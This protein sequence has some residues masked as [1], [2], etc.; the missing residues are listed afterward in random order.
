M[1]A[2]TT[3][4]TLNASFGAESKSSRSIARLSDDTLVTITRDF[5]SNDASNIY[6]Y[7]SSNN[8]ATFATALNFAADTVRPGYTPQQ[9]LTIDDADNLHIAYTYTTTS[10]DMG[11][12]Y[13]KLTRSGSTWTVGSLIVVVSMAG[14]RRDFVIDIDIA[15]AS[16]NSCP[17][18][19][20]ADAFPTLGSGSINYYTVNGSTVTDV[21]TSSLAGSTYYNK[22]NSTT[23]HYNTPAAVTCR[24]ANETVTGYIRFWWIKASGPNTFELHQY[25]GP[26]DG[27][28]SI[29]INHGALPFFPSGLWMYTT[30]D[31]EA[32]VIGVD[33]PGTN[34]F[35]LRTNGTNAA[36]LWKTSFRL[37]SITYADYFDGST[38]MLGRDVAVLI[39]Q[40]ADETFDEVAINYLNFTGDVPVAPARPYTLDQEAR[41]DKTFAGFNRSIENGV[42]HLD[43]AYNG[44]PTSGADYYRYVPQRVPP[45]LSGVTPKNGVT[46][47]TDT[48]SLGANISTDAFG[49]QAPYKITWQ[50]AKDSGFTTSVITYTSTSTYGDASAISEILNSL[51][52]LTSQ[53][54]WYFHARL[55]QAI[56]GGFVGAWSATT[57]F[58]NTHPPTV[59]ATEPLD[60]VTLIYGAGD[61][62]F[63]WMFHD[64]A[65]T[66]SQTA[67]EIVITDTTDDSLVED[68]G[69]ISLPD[70]SDIINIDSAYQDHLLS[71]VIYVW[72]SSD[73][74]S[75]ASSPET[76][77]VSTVPSPEFTSPLNGDVLSGSQLVVTWDPGTTGSK[78]EVKYRLLLEEAGTILYDT[79]FI[80]SVAETATIPSGKIHN[81]HSYALTI[82]VQDSLG[83]NG[84]QLISVDATF[85]P[86][87]PPDVVYAFD[88]NFE[89]MGY[90]WIGWDDSA[91]D[92]DFIAWNLYR[93]ADT[94]ADWT[95]LTTINS[96]NDTYGFADY[97]AQANT[98][99]QYA[100]TQVVNRAQLGDI[101]ESDFTAIVNVS[102]TNTQYWLIDPLGIADIVPLFNVTDDSSTDE[103]ERSSY[104]VV[105]A[106][107]HE[108][109]GEHLGLN[110]SLTIQARDADIGTLFANNVF[111]DPSF[112]YQIPFSPFWTLVCNGTLN[113]STQTFYEPSP[114][115][116]LESLRI[117]TDSNSTVQISQTVNE[118]PW[119][120]AGDTFWVSFYNC[121]LISSN[122]YTVS[123]VI[124][125]L[126][127]FENLIKVDFLDMTNVEDWQENGN[128]AR[129]A[130]SD[131]APA[132]CTSMIISVSITDVSGDGLSMLITGMQASQRLI[133]YIDG[134]FNGVQWDGLPFQSSSETNGFYTARQQR[135]DISG[136]AALS[137]P[138]YLRTPFGDIFQVSAGDMQRAHIAG[139]GS[140]SE[141][142][143]LTL[144]YLQVAL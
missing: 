21:A 114:S 137:R 49:E 59:V 77:Y 111:V 89:P 19:A 101:L 25:Y 113:L 27:S 67:Y 63:S 4:R 122:E 129:F 53:G 6:I 115:N 132:G 74:Q 107:R 58:I 46:L 39:G 51:N 109:I 110:G 140:Q 125:F 118:V 68:T 2:Y 31:M 32:T 11:L 45:A 104:T 44:A 43:V 60:G 69:K 20:L 5:T 9:S 82:V 65:P 138:L 73:I 103:Y 13:R 40:I 143:D 112:Q 42:Y 96:V 18:I 17:V 93:R 128:W 120:Y 106:G 83:L 14:S 16:T 95:L 117:D 41:V 23:G 3:V 50:F 66:D 62:L 72:D 52:Q 36:P 84:S 136:L 38:A 91:L 79:G 126:D 64:T 127:E 99:Y 130:V 29:D 131:I 76:F 134:T 30:G 81:G 56:P 135:Q 116:Q 119:Q 33:T 97:T 102:L 47:S 92:I 15:G 123:C 133:K 142:Q 1:V 12:A 28:S 80:T 141:M 105:G 144:P 124:S 71:Y 57:T 98:K 34:V 55:T 121:D 54:T 139:T 10:G 26:K 61:V 85:T 37:Y 78:T 86:P 35:V 87:L 24:H 90:M 75:I 7:T 48:P 70:S 22:L 94:D 100:V 108:D 8:G 88:Y